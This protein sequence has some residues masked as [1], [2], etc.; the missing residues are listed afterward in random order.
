ME[1]ISFFWG[2]C[3]LFGI[4]AN[5]LIKSMEESP[6]YKRCGSFLVCWWPHFGFDFLTSA[7]NHP[8]WRDFFS[9]VSLTV[10]FAIPSSV[11]NSFG[12]ILET[13]LNLWR[14]QQGMLPSCVLVFNSRL[15]CISR[16]FWSLGPKRFTMFLSSSFGI[17]D[18]R[19]CGRLYTVSYFYAAELFGRE[20]DLMRSGRRLSTIAG[21]WIGVGLIKP[22]M[23]KVFEPSSTY[24]VKWS[25]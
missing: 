18:R 20:M 3:L 8:F 1:E 7:S 17:N 25:L 5:N 2:N 19:T 11:F 6:Y 13:P 14:K 16:V 9:V 12:W 22:A 21:S 10:C 15:V 4:V 23:L 24:L